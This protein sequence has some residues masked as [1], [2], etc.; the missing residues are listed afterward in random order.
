MEQSHIL[1][2]SIGDTVPA[3]RLSAS[4]HAGRVNLKGKEVL[5]EVSADAVRAASDSRL[6]VLAELELYFCCLVRKQ[7][8][9]REIN[10]VQPQNENSSRVFPGLYA[11]FRAVTTSHCSVADVGD[12]PPVETMPV[13]QPERFVPDWIR[14]DYRAG[15]W[16]GEYGYARKYRQRLPAHPN[17]SHP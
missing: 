10:G 2:L 14:I 1:N 3:R 13:C 11:A 8:R 17:R 7:L 12:K 16:L 6:P 15:Q 9:F 5:I 4:A